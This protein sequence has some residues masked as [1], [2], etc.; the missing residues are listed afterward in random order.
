VHLSD[1]LMRARYRESTIAPKLVKAGN[2][3][4]YEFSGFTWF[5][6]RIAKGSRIRIVLDS[7]NSRNVEKNY[8]SGG[9]IA[10]ETAKD[11]RTAHISVYHDAEH[12]SFLELPVTE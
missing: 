2:I 4:R 8:N 3:E 7:P 11:A 1:D 6:R 12:A 9:V 10:D 5:S